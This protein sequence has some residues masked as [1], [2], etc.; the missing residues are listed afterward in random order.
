MT[1]TALEDFEFSPDE[2]AQIIKFASNQADELRQKGDQKKSFDKMQV[3][4]QKVLESQKNAMEIL[5]TQKYVRDLIALQQAISGMSAQEIID[6]AISGELPKPRQGGNM[7]PSSKPYSTDKF[8][9][10]TP[11]SYSNA[12][13]YIYDQEERSAKRA[14]ATVNEIIKSRKQNRDK[15]KNIIRHIGKQNSRS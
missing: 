1:A 12:Y 8:A 15:L 4:I 3:K 14:I 10:K 5:K 7:R 2:R 6:K 13:E 11:E 9:M